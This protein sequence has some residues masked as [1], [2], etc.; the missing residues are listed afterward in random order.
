MSAESNRPRQDATTTI[1]NRT[2]I[3]LYASTHPSRSL[4]RVNLD[5]YDLAEQR[6]ADFF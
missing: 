5:P 1:G 6:S 2:P 4:E 3:F